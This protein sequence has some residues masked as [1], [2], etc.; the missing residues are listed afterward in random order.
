MLTRRS[1][2]FLLALLACSLLFPQCSNKDN[3]TS[4][5]A[6]KPVPVKGSIVLPAGTSIAPEKLAILCGDSTSDVDTNGAFTSSILE[7]TPA[8][9]MAVDE[10]N[11]PVLMAV[12]ADPT[13]GYRPVLDARSTALALAFL[14][15]FV[16]S[17]TRADASEVLA[18]LENQAAF[19]DLVDLIESKLQADA[20]ALTAEDAEIDQLL[21][22]VIT[23]YVNSYTQEMPPPEV[24]SVPP[25]PP[26]KLLETAPTIQPDY[27]RSGHLLR[28]LGGNRFELTNS[29]GRWA[30]CCTPTDSFYVFP[31]G[32]FLDW[33]RAG[34]PWPPSRK[35]L[36]LPV[37]VTETTIVDIYG[38]GCLAVADNSWSALTDKEKLCAHYGGFVT[39]TFELCSHILGVV[40]NTARVVG[41]DALASR[42]GESLLQPIFSDGRVVQRVTAYMQANDPWGCS[43]FLTKEVLKK[44]VTSPSY[45][46]AFCVVTGITLTNGML[47]TLG[48]WLAV[49]AKVTLTFNS[50]SSAFKT[51]LALNSARFKTTFRVWKEY[52]EFGVIEGMVAE[53]TNG[54][55][56]AGATV[57]IGGDDNNPMNP[58]H[59]K[60]TDA[61]GHFRFE[62]IGVGARTVSASKTGYNRNQVEV[63]V[64][65]NSTVE[66]NIEL[67]REQ[68]GVSGH[69]RNDILIHHS[70]PSTLFKGSVSIHCRQI[71]GD[72]KTFDTWA[73]DGVA[74]F[75]LEQGTWWVI[76]GHDDYD[77]DSVQVVVP[78]DGSVSFPR[79][80]VLKPH[81]TMTGRIYINTDNSGGYELDFVPVFGQVGLSAPSL[82][83]GDCP[84]GGNQGMLLNAVAVRGTS[85]AD[86]D[87]VLFSARIDAIPEAGAYRMG[88]IEAYGCTGTSAMGAAALIT[89]RVKCTP[90]GGTPHSLAFTFLDD[91]ESRGCNCG[92]NEP[93][94]IFLT[95]WSTELGEIVA[96]TFNLD[97]AGWRGNCEC[98]GNDA[99]D[100]GIIDTWD[101]ECAQARVQIDFRLPV[102]SD[103][104]ITFWPSG[105]PVRLPLLVR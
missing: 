87:A 12:I 92:I 28:W 25:P 5:K 24:A 103:Y 75:S 79:D 19:D 29:F 102:G 56:I 59:E 98:G 100:D 53:K 48:S 94:D 21:T 7:H 67:E 17:A 69:V 22:D 66:A 65:K 20:S 101:V 46:E 57:T 43:W 61:D 86:Y 39:V 62:N 13:Q 64:V 68:A 44:I 27:E 97:L 91:P 26:A 45:R 96:G 73:E 85:N 16:C 78:A 2:R 88:G 74:A 52:T 6:L 50:V 42:I 89:T 80:L 10:Y 34:K 35:S 36:T 30:Y 41:N 18:A 1:F 93:G 76:A 81:P 40:C 4:S 38:Y 31:N 8:A 32:D 60:A 90:D 83:D 54:Q 14:N 99:D 37:S 104:L 9:L 49:P 77:P 105:V 55:G 51:A 82:Y 70:Q 84:L 23:S 58:P 11:H 71:G 72:Q 33:I 63:T 47:R 15:P 3:G 95:E